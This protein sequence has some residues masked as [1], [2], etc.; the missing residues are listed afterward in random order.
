MTA[1]HFAQFVISCNSKPVPMAQDYDPQPDD[2]AEFAQMVEIWD[3][4]QIIRNHFR[5]GDPFLN[6]ENPDIKT[7]VANKVVLMPVVE[8]MA[9][10]PGHPLPPVEAVRS[11]VRALYTL[12]KVQADPSTIS[13]DG[14][15]LRKYLGF[16]KMK[17]RR[18]EVSVE[19][20]TIQCMLLTIA[21]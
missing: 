17:V 16:I 3:S 15:L 9:E 18:S 7:T 12:N 11:A 2:G 14:W 13:H 6:G 21:Y 10:R 19:S 5:A 20:W 1:A 8:W 4:C